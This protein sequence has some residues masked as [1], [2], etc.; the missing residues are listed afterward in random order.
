VEGLFGWQQRDRE[1]SAVAESRVLDQQDL[2]PG[3]CPMVERREITLERWF[4]ARVGK[5]S[6][7]VNDSPASEVTAD[8]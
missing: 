5:V 6:E 8:V 2:L 7:V 1:W 4:G 3:N